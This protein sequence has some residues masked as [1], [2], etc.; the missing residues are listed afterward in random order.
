MKHTNNKKLSIIQRFSKKQP[1]TGISRRNNQGGI[2]RNT[3]NQSIGH[4]R[5]N[6][7]FED[8]YRN[9]NREID[10]ILSTYGGNFKPDFGAGNTLNFDQSQNGWSVLLNSISGK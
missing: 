7:N 5:T 4:N 6:L 1:C 2:A 3:R 9:K 10:K 8:S